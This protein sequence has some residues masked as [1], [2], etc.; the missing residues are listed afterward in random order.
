MTRC[1]IKSDRARLFIEHSINF[2]LNGEHCRAVQYQNSGLFIYQL[3]PIEKTGKKE[4]NRRV[5]FMNMH[6]FILSFIFCY[7]VY[8]LFCYRGYSPFEEISLMLSRS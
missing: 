3:I 1:L 7:D 8:L 2:H 6:T 4:N 5:F